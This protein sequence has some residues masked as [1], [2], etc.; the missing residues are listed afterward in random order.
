MTSTLP[1]DDR[2]IELT[3]DLQPSRGFSPL[4]HRV[5]LDGRGLT[6]VGE[7]VFC[8]WQVVRVRTHPLATASVADR[9]QLRIA[10]ETAGR[11][12]PFLLRT[13]RRAG[14]DAVLTGA[15]LAAVRL[16]LGTVFVRSAAEMAVFSG[17]S[18]RQKIIKHRSYIYIY[19][20]I[21]QY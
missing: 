13:Q 11:R 12:R 2:S 3:A 16:E 10:A 17:F 21:Y 19:I 15:Q 8:T 9:D 20:Y 6:G 14:V 4:R 18:C 1:A 5:M 7:V